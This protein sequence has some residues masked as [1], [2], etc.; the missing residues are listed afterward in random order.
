MKSTQEKLQKRVMG[1][2]TLMTPEVVAKLEQVFAIDGT[3]E[4]ACSYAEISRNTFYDYVK[5]NTDFSNR[6]EDLR[7]RP[8]LKA[9]Q[10]VV[11]SLSEPNN[12]FRYLE[13]KRRQEFGDTVPSAI[14]AVQVNVVGT[15]AELE[16][17]R[18]KYEEELR[19][20]LLA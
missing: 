14:T 5:K 15:G 7:Q 12:A 19:T 16:K 8:I 4:E 3:V 13:K 6:I 2:P 17:L 11:S 1:R 9:R 10:T 20:K 18:E